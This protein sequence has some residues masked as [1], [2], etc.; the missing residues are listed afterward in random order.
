MRYLLASSLLFFSAFSAEAQSWV[1]EIIQAQYQSSN[2][3]DAKSIESTP[4]FS[5]YAPTVGSKR[6]IAR[7]GY[8]FVSVN[9]EETKKQ[10]RL[11][12]GISKVSLHPTPAVQLIINW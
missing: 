4:I 3:Q 11:R 12:W 5:K 6:D 9:D 10:I 2:A 7:I 8:D 1:K